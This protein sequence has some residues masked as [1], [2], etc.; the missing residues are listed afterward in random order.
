M[1]R[2]AAARLAGCF[3]ALFAALFAA[4][5]CEGGGDPADRAEWS[6][7]REA[8]LALADGIARQELRAFNESAR[9]ARMEVTFRLEDFERS[10]KRAVVG[11]HPR[12]FILYWRGGENPFWGHPQNFGVLVFAD[13]GEAKLFRGN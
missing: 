1:N 10:M 11:G 6:V 13:T 2:A 3:L 7:D 12:Y 4:T 5:G 9:A 8:A